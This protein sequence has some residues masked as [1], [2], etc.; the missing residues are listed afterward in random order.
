MRIAFL[1]FIFG[2]IL[3]G[4]LY[5]IY[6]TKSYKKPKQIISAVVSALL[7]AYILFTCNSDNVD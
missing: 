1:L 4:L 7:L 5:S 6:K 2:I 3:F